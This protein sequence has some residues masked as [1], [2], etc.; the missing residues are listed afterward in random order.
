[1]AYQ[2]SSHKPE[3][4]W[5]RIWRLIKKW[6]YIWLPLAIVLLD[7]LLILWPYIPIGEATFYMK[8]QALATFDASIWWVIHVAETI[9]LTYL[10]LFIISA[11]MYITIWVI[12][13]LNKIWKEDKYQR[14]LE[15]TAIKAAHEAIA[16]DQVR[17]LI[18]MMHKQA[19]Q[20]KFLI[21]DAPFG[22][23]MVQ[24]VPRQEYREQKKTMPSFRLPLIDDIAVTYQELMER[25]FLFQL[26]VA[27]GMEFV[28]KKILPDPDHSKRRKA[29]EEV[30]QY[31]A[32]PQPPARA[33]GLGRPETAE[34]KVLP[35]G[36]GPT[37]ETT[38]T[39]GGG[40]GGL[41]ASSDSPQES[42][43][44]HPAAML[45]G[46]ESKGPEER[47]PAAA[48]V[49]SG[50]PAWPAASAPQQEGP[51]VACQ[52]GEKPAVVSEPPVST[53]E[54]REEPMGSA[55]QVMS[56]DVESGVQAQAVAEPV[57]E[58][59]GAGLATAEAVPVAQAAASVGQVAVQ[60]QAKISVE[61]AL[62]L[63]KHTIE[64]KNEVRRIAG[65]PPLTAAE[66][67]AIRQT[68]FSQVDPEELA[69]WR[70]GQEAPAS[71]ASEEPEEGR[72]AAVGTEQ[73]AHQAEEEGGLVGVGAD[74][75]DEEEPEWDEDDEGEEDEQ[76]SPER[77]LEVLGQAEGNPLVA[78]VM[79]FMEDR[80]EWRGAPRELLALLKLTVPEEEQNS[81]DWPQNTVWLTRKFNQYTNNL[82]HKG[83]KI[84]QGRSNKGS[85]IS[86][87][88]QT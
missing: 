34:V 26:I 36:V 30:M 78:A 65:K 22:Q 87:H 63:I 46:A 2:T 33:R 42:S 64:P 4:K 54:K 41:Q 11:H 71:A 21:S 75:R 76:V 20:D 16:Q 14:Q 12:V 82:D 61:R 56:A 66:E 86:L 59:S 83:I 29:M 24:Y 53:E 43:A 31:F 3:T 27:K 81:T 68:I 49:E 80:D 13:K 40:D 48:M 39:A 37:A 17:I 67:E 57:Q 18:K 6:H 44:A 88:R 15:K 35:A 47:Q 7:R 19:K 1:M 50:Q 84:I 9:V 73:A 85:Y 32:T 10:W 79:L 45:Q 51:G 52:G 58:R 23:Y 77:W 70:A 38:R 69:A 5:Q 8:A 62:E 74:D 55:N 28:E 72:R 60:P 25:S